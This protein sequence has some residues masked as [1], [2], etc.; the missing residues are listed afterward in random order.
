LFLRYFNCEF[1]ST[2]FTRIKINE[3]SGEMKIY[4]RRSIGLGVGDRDRFVSCIIFR[5]SSCEEILFCSILAN[6]SVSS[7]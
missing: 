6:E 3:K 2:G 1:T 5:S 4:V 7:C